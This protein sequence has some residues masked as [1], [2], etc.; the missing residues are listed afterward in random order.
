MKKIQN[1]NIGD[2][3]HSGVYR[4]KCDTTPIKG[5]RYKCG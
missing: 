3:V 1:V 5:V 4:D 2:D